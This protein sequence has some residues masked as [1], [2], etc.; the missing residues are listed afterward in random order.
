MPSHGSTFLHLDEGKAAAE[1]EDEFM[2]PKI[3]VNDD[4]AD[5]AAAE[6]EDDEETKGKIDG[7]EEARKT[8]S[9]K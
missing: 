2:E 5:N 8:D 4:G 1:E 7:S 3:E 6:D 9:S